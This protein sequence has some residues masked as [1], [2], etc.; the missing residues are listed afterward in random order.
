M[1]D[2]SPSYWDISKRLGPF[3]LKVCPHVFFFLNKIYLM[4]LMQNIPLLWLSIK[5]F[6]LYKR[7]IM[8]PKRPIT[9]IL[10][11][12]YKMFCLSDALHSTFTF[13]TLLLLDE[14]LL[15]LQLKML[16]SNISSPPPTPKRDFWSSKRYYGVLAGDISMLPLDSFAV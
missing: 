4:Y 10:C 13:V 8:H 9:N 12:L 14:L 1:Q 7:K 11:I 15:P 5:Y 2:S 3:Y 6:T 16:N